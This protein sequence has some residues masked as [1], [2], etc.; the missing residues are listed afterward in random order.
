MQRTQ[1]GE[2]GG[3]A[4]DGQDP[5]RKTW[6]QAWHI[7]PQLHPAVT[8]I[9]GRRRRRSRRRSTMRREEKSK[10]WRS[11]TGNSWS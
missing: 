3:S 9:H 6:G 10:V 8:G 1:S 11:K 2:T 5:T 4:L 7:V